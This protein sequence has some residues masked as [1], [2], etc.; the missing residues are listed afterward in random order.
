MRYKLIAADN[1]THF[2]LRTGAPL[3][4][5]RAPTSDIPVFD[6][7]ISRRHA[8]VVV[9]DEGVHVRDL[10]SSN[11]TFLNGAKIET[12]S[13][14]LGDNITF[15][16]V[17]FT[18][19]RIM[20]TPA[21]QPVVEKAQDAP[22]GATIVRSVP[23]VPGGT[24]VGMRAATPGAAGAGGAAAA[25]PDLTQQK[26]SILL[27]VSKGLGRAVDTDSMLE[28][29]VE[30][31][32]QI[33]DVDRVAIL[34][35]DEAGELQP[36]IGRDKRGTDQPRAVP[37]S[38]ARV[39]VQDKVAILSDNAGEDQRFGGASILMQQIRSAV[40]APLV[41]SEDRVLGVIYVD[42]ISTHRFKEDDLEF[43]VAFAGIAAVAIENSQFAE[44]IR[45]ELLARSNFERYFTPQLAAR[46]ASSAEGT[47]LGGDK[48]PVAVLFSDIRGF[49]ALSETMLPDEM[50][51]ILN[52]YFSE[53]VDC[54]FRNN[55][56]LD[57]FIGDAVMAQWGAPIHTP[58]DADSAMQAAI[59]MMHELDKLNARWKAEGHPEL[60]IG[61]G[62]NYGEA[63]AG[64]IGSER[65]LEY[66]VIG[67]TVNTASRLCGAADGG[68]ILLSEDMKRVLTKVPELDECPPMELKGKSQPV[69]VYRVRR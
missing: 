5:G 50:A 9:N 26:L 32:Y 24:V 54:V 69:P 52:Q 46:I 16:K 38:I 25:Q 4:V 65:R 62:L 48:R 68:E 57:K 20:E 14:A 31:A 53:M 43:V 28:K 39:A 56:T 40:C 58:E 66:T 34:L 7:T 37:Q 35:M 2:D 8:E 42:N 61:I 30:Y 19:G 13:L 10:G 45:K 12:A 22:P 55:G 36:K 64:N 29:I 11:G 17:A 63:F 33:L 18:L 3:V 1:V 23:I 27:E 41:A 6:P 49:T 59:E 51:S 60:Q 67:D 21:P 44:R 47:K 15:G